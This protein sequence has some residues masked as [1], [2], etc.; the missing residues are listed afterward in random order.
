M[1]I[2][3]VIII[4]GFLAF[5]TNNE[6]IDVEDNFDWHAKYIWNEI[7]ENEVR[8]KWV[9]F[10]KNFNIDNKNDIKDVVCRIAADSKYWLY[11]NGEIVVREIGRAHV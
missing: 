3:V 7:E 2:I 11:I 4:L 10:R 8:N 6:H 5:R 1:L 9:C